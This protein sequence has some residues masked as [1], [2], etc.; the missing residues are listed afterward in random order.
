MN[1]I[2]NSF[3][4]SVLDLVKSHVQ[5]YCN[6][7]KIIV[8]RGVPEEIKLV[9]DSDFFLDESTFGIEAGNDVFDR[10]WFANV[11]LKLNSEQKMLIASDS[12]FQYIN[13]YIDPSF[14]KERIIVI[15][16]NIRSF[17]PLKEDYFIPG[18][19]EENSELRN[20]RLPVHHME[21]FK[22]DGLC[23]FSPKNYSEDYNTIS[24]FND[25]LNVGFNENQKHIL[26]LNNDN[27]PLEYFINQLLIG[28]VMHKSVGIAISQKNPIYQEVLKKIEQLNYVL[29][30]CDVE[31]SIIRDASFVE[32]FNPS[33]EL[34]SLL[35]TYWGP[36][37]NFRNLII[38]KNPET[39]TETI[40]ISQGKVVQLIIDEYSNARS[41]NKYRDLLLTAPTGAGKSLLFQLPA[42]HISH[43]G[44]VT[45][46]VSP[47][48]A[49]MKDQ[50]MTIVNERGFEK[51]AYLNSTLSLIERE[52]IIDSIKKGELDIVYLSPELLLSYDVS[53][54]LG[55]RKLGLLVID[56]AHLITT[57]G[58]DFRVDYWFLGNHIRKIRVQN[59]HSFPMVAVTAT[60]IYGGNNDM[61]FD[62]ETSLVMNNPHR[63]IG[64]VK[65]SNIEFVINNYSKFDGGY[66]QKKLKQTVDFI[67]GLTSK[68]KLKTLVYAPYSSHVNSIQRELIAL[69]NKNSTVYYGE[70]DKNIK[71]HSYVE[72]LSG[73]KQVMI[74]TK[75]FG[76][77]VDIPNIQVVYHHAPSGLLPDYVQEVGRLARLPELKGFA[78]LNYSEQDK[79]YTKVLHGMSSLK[80][81]QLQE[82]LKKITNLYQ[83]Q[84]SQ[85]LLLSVEEFSHIFD[86]QDSLDAK[87]LTALMMIEKDYI[88]KYRFNVLIARPKKLFVK[89][90]ARIADSQLPG[91][92]KKYGKAIEVLP[93][94]LLDSKGYK[95]LR[96][97]LDDL[98]EKFYS[99]ESFP[100]IKYKY[101]NGTL[102]SDIADSLTPQLRVSYWPKVSKK[103][104]SETI[105]QNFSK[106]KRAFEKLG[107]GFFSEEEFRSAILAEFKEESIGIKV[108]GFILSNFAGK[109]LYGDKVEENAFMGRRQQGKEMKYRIISTLYNRE[110]SKV[111]NKIQTT[112]DESSEETMRFITNNDMNSMTYIRI[113]QFLEL[114]DLGSYEIK[115][116]DK[117]MIFLRLN[118]PKR[119]EKDS[120]GYYNNFI[121][122]KTL[123]RHYLSNQIFDH[124]FL[125]QFTNDER[126]AFIEDFFLGKDIDELIE[127]YPGQPNIKEID[128]IEFLKLNEGSNENTLSTIV[129]ITEVLKFPP[130][131]GQFY[132]S[133]SLLTIEVDDKLET[134]NISKWLQKDPVL[135]HKIGEEY[136]F[137]YDKEVFD[138]L[139]SR[140]RHTDYWIEYRGLQIQ[141][142]FPKY[143]KPVKAIVAYK[144]YP[145]E[146]YLWWKND[147]KAVKL[148]LK[149]K[150]E[151][152][153]QVSK[154]APN[155]VKSEDRKYL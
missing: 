115:G 87:V 137:K 93:Y 102:F 41:G 43:Y 39:S 67:D 77:G 72:F 24:I 105:T 37:A 22:V 81:Y 52:R 136:E 126:W 29:K 32:E 21:Q 25:S 135:L 139:V 56:E 83:K 9:L 149:E 99:D 73:E 44:D 113:G 31:L 120:K 7:N 96:I 58:R 1:N 78:A 110:F 40:E 66:N 121:L 17:Y 14:F 85:N 111:E 6:S 63:F 101:Y 35:Q 123:D 103:N 86:S 48:I 132:K 112:L 155:K 75:A 45:I 143:S 94:P 61:V 98:W 74:S 147:T 65:R 108:S 116:G 51:V 128:I 53:F 145:V 144:E 148:T 36:S 50:V 107:G 33:N 84:K 5:G 62:T 134:L 8:L 114:F 26:D 89:S 91:F 70:L 76:M 122:K 10:A 97:N 46:V 142:E 129:P 30:S 64:S 60:A 141:I 104:I 95:I 42:F 15:E 38:Y 138:V 140:L 152:I 92:L 4:K 106:L 117:P 19:E 79:L 16:D 119:I 59:G 154:R 127:M 57:W 125:H 69:E 28:R 54:F 150:I 100:K 71:D 151:L 20:Q 146:F 23:Y 109:L 55:D 27:F 80:S 12:Q 124:F 82:V 131:K 47:L 118:D 49:L 18:V 90:Y 88:A 3:L 11:F 2:Q 153:L 133:S 13:E 68:T 34:K 130:I